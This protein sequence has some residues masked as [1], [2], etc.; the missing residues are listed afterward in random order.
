M[1][2]IRIEKTDVGFA[3]RHSTFSQ[4]MSGLLLALMLALAAVPWVVF[5]FNGIPQSTGTLWL[6][7]A[8]SIG[9]AGIGGWLFYMSMGQ[10][11]VL[12]HEGVRAYH[13]SRCKR[14]MPWKY[15][16]S[17][18]I[19]S[20]Q[21]R[22]QYRYRERYCLYFSAKAGERYGKNCI[23]LPIHPDEKQAIRQTGLY[24]FVVSHRPSEGEE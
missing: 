15:V 4:V 18:G 20:V 23:T 13:F 9:L 7:A 19:T 11:V 8:C 14:D 22:P 16:K 1:K 17:W 6:A 5:G 12:D 21:M 3:L 10:R 2:H 24:D